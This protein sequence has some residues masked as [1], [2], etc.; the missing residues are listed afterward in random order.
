MGEV[1]TRKLPGGQ[2]GSKRWEWTVR[3][4]LWVSENGERRDQDRM[5]GS[6]GMILTDF[7]R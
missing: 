5:E 2:S 1:R 3:W 6:E 4:M 7:T